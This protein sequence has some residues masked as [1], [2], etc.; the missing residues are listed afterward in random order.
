MLAQLQQKYPKDVRIVFRHFPLTQ[1]NKSALAAQAAEAAGLQGKFWEMH[2]VLY[3]HQSD[4]VTMTV[5]QFEDWLKTQ[6][7]ALS[8]DV[9]RF[10]TDLHSDAVVNKVKQALQNAEKAGIPGTPFLL[11]NGKPYSY[12]SPVEMA[13]L[14]PVVQLYTLTQRQFDSCPTMQ[15]DPHKAYSATLHTAKGDIVVQLYPGQAP[16]TVNSFVFLARQ[17]WFDGM[18]FHRVLAGYI[19]QTGDPSGT[20]YGSPGYYFS[21]EIDPKLKFDA[22]GVVGMANAG[23]DSNG[24]QFFITMAAAPNLDGKYTIFG[25]VIQGMDVVQ[26]LTPRDP[27][28]GN[29]LPPGDV[30]TSVTIEEK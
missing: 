19:A 13:N 16:V 25:K 6:A 10:E 17:H 14:E 12:G 11:I 23:P 29:D 9:D 4:W 3:A 18:T 26:K 28:Q 27:A 22:P 2:D 7:A 20:G 1:H 21:D 24:S 5:P 8:L 30:I 15:I